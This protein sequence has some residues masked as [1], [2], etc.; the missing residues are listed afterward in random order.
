[1]I[2][3]RLSEAEYGLLRAQCRSIGARNVSPLT[4]LAIQPILVEP[5]FASSM[6]SSLQVL[7]GRISELERKFDSIGADIGGPAKQEK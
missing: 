5:T 7:G 3:V 2:S 1:M 4:R 6:G